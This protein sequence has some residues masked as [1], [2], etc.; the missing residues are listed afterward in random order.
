MA[1]VHLTR[2]R[3]EK[4]QTVTS[5][6]CQEEYVEKFFKRGWKVEEKQKIEPVKAEEPKGEEPV[7]VEEPKVEE[8][9]KEGKKSK[10]LKNFRDVED[11]DLF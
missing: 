3:P 1:L 2:E 4:G 6:K 9:E 5:M 7:K 8:S 11:K 10:K